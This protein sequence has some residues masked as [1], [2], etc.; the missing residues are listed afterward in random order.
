MT[1]GG[2]HTLGQAA[3]SRADNQYKLDP[4]ILVLFCSFLEREEGRKRG[5]GRGRDRDRERWCWIVRILRVLREEKRKQSLV[6]YRSCAS[7]PCRSYVSALYQETVEQENLTDYPHISSSGF[8]LPLMLIP[9][10]IFTWTKIAWF[11]SL[12]QLL[13][14]PVLCTHLYWMWLY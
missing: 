2:N 4:M 8:I 1:R 9:L 11:N 6:L 3:C 10:V 14:T 7:T 5:W 13:S 12:V